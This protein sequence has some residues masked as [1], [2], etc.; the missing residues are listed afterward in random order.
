MTI[1]SARLFLL[2]QALREFATELGRRQT[3]VGGTIT[4][5]A[6]SIDA[7]V[8]LWG[9]PLPSAA[10]EGARH[11]V[12]EVVP[13]VGIIASLCQ[14]VNNLATHTE[15]CAEDL[16]GLEQTL[17]DIAWRRSQGA[18]YSDDSDSGWLTERRIDNIVAGWE[19]D[20]AWY[21]MVME[22]DTGELQKCQAIT[23]MESPYPGP[24]SA[25]DFLTMVASWAVGNG[26]ELS[27][28]DPTGEFDAEAKEMA[29]AL[30]TGDGL[31]GVM[32]T[33][34][35][36]MDA[37]LAAPD[38][39]FSGDDVE[40]STDLGAVTERWREANDLYNLGLSDEEITRWAQLTVATALMMRASGTE[41]WDDSP[42]PPDIDNIDVDSIEEELAKVDP[43]FDGLGTCLTASGNAGAIA[44]DGGTCLVSTDGDMGQIVWYGGGASGS[45]LL[46]PTG[47]PGVGAGAGPILTNAQ[48][49]NDLG[50]Y[51]VCFTG[52]GGAGA[53]GSGTICGSVVWDHNLA[54]WQFNGTVTAQ[55]SVILTTPGA[56]IT[57]TVV[58]TRVVWRNGAINVIREPVEAAAEG[59]SNAWNDFWNMPRKA[60][61]AFRHAR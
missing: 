25:T 8:P 9:G 18:P 5:L 3:T 53:G 27:D 50:G 34:I 46:D 56:D 20:A 33:I 11:Y 54:K 4:E 41:P 24:P 6:T 32:F 29:T 60:S 61:D 31:N 52:S 19:R 23:A 1:S 51:S 2:A 36:T 44:G 45:G 13:A 16:A 57:V 59:A 22:S 43:D 49:I 10:V 38:G 15:G 7:V 55:G 42:D 17:A 14:T 39:I 28:I 26:Y 48:N 35:E 40:D 12:G 37:E 58:R 30:N 21:A 47:T